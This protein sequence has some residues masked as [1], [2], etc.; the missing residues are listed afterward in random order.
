MKIKFLFASLMILLSLQVD[1]QSI[2]EKGENI[3]D[4][5]KFDLLNFKNEKGESKITYNGKNYEISF[6]TLIRPKFVYEVSKSVSLKKNKYSKDDIF[7]LKFK[8][9]SNFSDLETGESKIKCI[10]S[11]SKSYKGFLSRTLSLSSKW[12]EYYIPYKLTMDIPMNELKLVFHLG[13]RKQLFLMKDLELIAFEDKVKVDELPKTKISYVGMESDAEW[14]KAAFERIDSIRK[15]DFEINFFKDHKP[16]SATTVEVSMQEHEFK[17]G[18]AVRAKDFATLDKQR[19][20][21]YKD[22]FNL[23]VIENGLKMK[24]WQRDKKIE[25]T[26]SALKVLNSNGIEVKGHVLLWPGFKYLPQW[27]SEKDVSKEKVKKYIIDHIDK[28]LLLTDGYVSHWDVVNEAYTN[29]DIQTLMGSE[30]LLYEAFNITKQRNPNTKR[31]TNEYGIIS[32][33]GID[34]AKIKWYY[35]Y[36]KRLDKNT[37]GLVD[38]IGIQSHIGSDLTPPKKVLDILDYYATL[39]KDIS[40]SEFTMSIMDDDIRRSY[41]KDFI[42]AAFSHPSVT[43]FLFWGFDSNKREMAEIYDKD[44]NLAPMGQSYM[45]LVKY[46]WN[47]KLRLT[48]NESGKV[49][50]KA[51]YGSY[52]FKITVE[53]KVYVGIIPISKDSKNKIRIDL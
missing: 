31:F 29:N 25:E 19:M 4:Y 20:K 28:I 13:Y 30:D 22:A 1:S 50:G 26:L 34:E 21:Y 24:A 7:L 3:I 44:W 43:E 36:I 51:F 14:R 40:I 49:S 45:K 37:G 9:K 15:G 48:T 16:V 10:L 38:G 5:T 32:K 17:W 53:G 6:E 33:G 35:D 41:T 8:A 27:M 18:A 46:I 23:A 52:K 39:D 42:I 12:Q 2:L 47:T 11:Q